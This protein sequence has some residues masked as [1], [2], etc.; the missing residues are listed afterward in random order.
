MSPEGDK[1]APTKSGGGVLKW[2][3]IGCLL[4]LLVGG[5]CA[6]GGIMLLK[7]AMT[8]SEAYK[9]ALDKAGKHAVV[10]EKIGTDLELN[11]L[12]PKGNVS[13]QNDSGSA[14]LQIPVKGSKGTGVISVNATM[15]GGK[16]NIDSLTV[17]VDGT[18]ESIVIIGGEGSGADGQ[19]P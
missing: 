2:L 1:Q 7:G 10:I 18:G 6:V 13:M 9:M 12:I 11:S 5:G 8:G 4:V 15:T 14:N 16:W 3:A 19:S 17:V